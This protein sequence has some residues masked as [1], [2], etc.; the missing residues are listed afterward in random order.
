MA[1][2]KITDLPAITSVAITDLLPVESDPP[3]TPVTSKI[4]I[5]NFIATIGSSIASITAKTTPVD[6]DSI[7]ISDSG[8]SS[9]SKK[10][11]WAN[12]KATLKTYFDTLYPAT[13]ISRY[14]LIAGGQI[15]PADATTYYFGSFPRMV[16]STTA[17]TRRIYIPRAGTISTVTLG[18]YN[19]G[20][21][22]GSNE[23]STVSIRKNNTTDTT[24]TSTFD[25]NDASGAS[26]FFNI[27]GLSI[28][29]VAGDYI[30][31]KW[32]TPTW[33]TNPTAVELWAQVYI[34]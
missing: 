1:D 25:T 34:D 8:A 31:F 16:A 23:T 22:Q 24:V 21:T 26:S 14:S 3:G 13:A 2:S 15:A 27:T 17:D 33:A 32:V 29:V 9:V 28:S 6:G 10:V 19:N 30:E 5:L 12:V 18:V 7:I 20:G 11:T 4:T